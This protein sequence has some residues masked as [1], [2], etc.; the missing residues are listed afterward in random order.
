MNLFLVDECLSDAMTVIN[1]SGSQVL[2]TEA[3]RI[4]AEM[5]IKMGEYS[6][7]A[8]VI[9]EHGLGEHKTMLTR[10]TE[11]EIN[12]NEAQSRQ[13]Y[14]NASFFLDQILSE[15]PRYTK[16]IVERT[17]I[18]WK[19][20][21][22][23]T[24]VKH[25]RHLL[26]SFPENSTILHRLGVVYF[27]NYSFNNSV[28]YFNSSTAF[29]PLSAFTQFESDFNGALE[30][31]SFGN[32]SRLLES[33]NSTAISVCPVYTRL[34][35][36]VAIS[37]SRMYR[38]FGRFE[39]SAAVL[40][41]WSWHWKEREYL[42]EKA[43]LDLDCHR[44]DLAIAAFTKL[45][46]DHQLERANLLKRRSHFIDWYAFLGL[47]RDKGATFEEIRAAYR[48]VVR[49]WHPDLF[50]DRKKKK[51]AEI[52]MKRINSA[53][54]ILS[55]PSAKANYDRGL[56]PY[57]PGSEKPTEFNPYQEFFQSHDI[58]WPKNMDGPV[59]ISVEL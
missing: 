51:E 46:D 27:C 49:I 44:F 23:D 35:G 6:K 26:E 9:D 58:Q 22:F 47:D 17:E 38:R 20:Q 39:E 59:R 2:K 5:H 25:E 30:A 18:A 28:L 34:H 8:L 57:D 29:E 4:M 7:A 1:G 48:K 10:L 19:V 3:G 54:D 42:L 11:L 36:H 33:M 50:S 55:N 37:L 52:L 45:G 43:A 13:D 41:N 15:S 21:D 24:Y 14:E 53:Y 56:D 40:G 12:V 16:L 31:L 32:A